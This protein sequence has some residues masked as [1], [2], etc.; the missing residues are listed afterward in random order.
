MAERPS[1][2]EIEAAAHMLDKAGRLHHWWKGK[3]YGELDSISKSEFEG[4]VEQM[5]IA[6]AKAK[7]AT[8]K[9]KR[10]Q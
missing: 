10:D 6:A 8:F 3:P 4:I 5:L 7:G 1:R 2:Q 9:L